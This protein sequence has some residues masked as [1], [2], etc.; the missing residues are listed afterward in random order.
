MIPA[1]EQQLPCRTAPELFHAPDGREPAN[2]ALARVNAAK[3]LC[4]TC[5]VISACRDLGRRLHETGVWGGETDEER[6]GA[7]YKPAPKAYFDTTYPDCGSPAA[8]KRH[9]RKGADP[10]PACRAAE[11]KYHRE[12]KHRQPPTCGT[13]P[14]YQRHRRRGETPCEACRIA[15]S[16]ADRRLR[17]T[18]STIAA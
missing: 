9:R 3:A 8:A 17:Q 14:G 13:R 16:Q 6:T 4:T 10:C 2:A 18:G 1:I 15:N 5:P 12:R 11:A 7:G